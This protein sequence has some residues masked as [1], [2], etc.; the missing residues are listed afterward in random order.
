[1][2]D[3]YRL[4]RSKDF[5][6]AWLNIVRLE[7]RQMSDHTTWLCD[8]SWLDIY[9]V[10]RFATKATVTRKMSDHAWASNSGCKAPGLPTTPQI[11]SIQNNYIF[12][13]QTITTIPHQPVATTTDIIKAQVCFQKTRHPMS[14]NDRVNVASFDISDQLSIDFFL[15]MLISPV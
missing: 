7:T 6:T 5:V 9:R 13:H 3:I 1:M 15:S 2:P 12:S 10:S 4:L 11:N 8:C 14:K